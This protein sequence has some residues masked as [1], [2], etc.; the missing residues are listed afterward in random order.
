[1]WENPGMIQVKNLC[2]NYGTVKALDHVSFELRPAEILGLLGP[3]GAGKTTAIHI[4]LGLL[5]PTSGEV[6]VL[7]L[8]PMTQRHAISSQINF[9]SAYVQLPSNLKVSENLDIFSKIYSV[10]NARQKTDSLLELFEI[11]H[12][13]GR[14]TGALSAGEKTRIN[15]VKCLLNDPKLLLLDE[16][17]A[18]LDP[19]MA[20]TVRKVLK[21]IQKE[22]NMGILY[23]SHNMPE[24][25][26]ICDRVLFIHEGKTITQGTPESIRQNFQS[27]TLEQVFIKIVRKGDFVMEK[28][29]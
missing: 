22:R 29:P 19:E 8:S 4:L 17:T 25:E 20:D 1:L 3:N 10:K 12:L 2:K 15:L 14:L 28:R 5:S 6:S 16:P 18:S 9:S 21:K 24:V 7:G 23:T 27:K 13:R 11:A 26:E